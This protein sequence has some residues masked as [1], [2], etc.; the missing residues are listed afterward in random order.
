[1]L[2]TGLIYNPIM[3]WHPEEDGFPFLSLLYL[4]ISSSHH[5]WEISLATPA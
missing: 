1:M 4:E 2:H 3:Y 5:I